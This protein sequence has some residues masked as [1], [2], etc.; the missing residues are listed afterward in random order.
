MTHVTPSRGFIAMPVSRHY[1]RALTLVAAGLLALLPA[2]TRAQ[3]K[4]VTPALDFSGVMYANFRSASDSA[5]KAANGGNS[6]NKFDLERVYLNFRM[7]AGQ[8]A[9]IR[10]T[11]DVFNNTNASTNGYYPGWTVRVKYAWLQYNYL[12][13]IGG[14]KGFNAVARFGSLQTVE[15]DHEEQFWARWMSLTAIERNSFFSSADL[16]VATLVTLPNKWGEIYATV[17]NGPGYGSA[18][19]DRFKDVAARI[20]LTPFGSES[21]FLKSFTITPWF[22]AGQTAS[23]FQN[24]G[25]GQTGLVTDGLNRNRMGGFIGLKDRRLTMGLDYA[26]RTETIETGANTAASPRGTYENTGTLTAAFAMVRPFELADTA[27]SPLSIF[28]RVDNFKPNSDARSATGGQTTSSSQQQIIAGIMYDLNAKTTVSLD[29][30]TLSRQS[31]STV[32]EQK[33]LFLHLVTNF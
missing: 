33:I 28:A 2:A 6:A 29:W 19:T 11:T 7:P 12:H 25:T 3:E 9:S 15:I 13:D 31:G 32:S 1:S 17:T 21:G 14:Y 4:V 10:F 8:D 24:G 26:T 22:Y 23:K 30:Q 18:E 16:G 27:K 20:S 5:S